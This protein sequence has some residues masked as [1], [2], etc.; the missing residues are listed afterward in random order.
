MNG[1]I[2]EILD[3]YSDLQQK[4]YDNKGSGENR[5]QDYDQLNLSFLY[6]R[7]AFLVRIHRPL[8]TNNKAGGIS[9]Q[10]PIFVR[11]T[12]EFHEYK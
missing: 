7:S 5:E 6:N 3:V 11:K 4:I 2:S 10:H 9:V 8:N 1:S 12:H